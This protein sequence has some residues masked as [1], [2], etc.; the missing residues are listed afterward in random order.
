MP[1][2][3]NNPL[4]FAVSR[5]L[6]RDLFNRLLGPEKA[7]TML[8]DRETYKTMAQ[9]TH[10]YHTEAGF[11]PAMPFHVITSDKHKDIVFAF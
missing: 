7:N 5:E 6:A 9:K 10:L 1:E 8:T 3:Q 4:A 2:T 11:K